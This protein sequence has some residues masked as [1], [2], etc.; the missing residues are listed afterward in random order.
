MEIAF[1]SGL[2]IFHDCQ[3]LQQQVRWPVIYFCPYLTFQKT[4]KNPDF[5]PNY[6]SILF[7]KN[8]LFTPLEFQIFSELSL[9]PLEEYA[10][11]RFGRKLKQ[12]L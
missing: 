11:R 12:T 2:E 8:Y 6:P 10:V 1:S 5:P 9:T 4:E 7:L 3:F